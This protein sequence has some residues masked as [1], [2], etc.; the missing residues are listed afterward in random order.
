[1]RACFEDTESEELSMDGEQ[2]QTWKGRSRGTCQKRPILLAVHL[3]ATALTAVALNLM[4]S[5]GQYAENPT[6]RGK[7]R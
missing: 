7:S 4:H 3:P 5:D 6:V 1:M 2:E